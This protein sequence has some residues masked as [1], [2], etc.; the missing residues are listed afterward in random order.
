MNATPAAAKTARAAMAEA[1]EFL[2]ELVARLGEEGILESNPEIA[3]MADE[4]AT[5]IHALRNARR[6]L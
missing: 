3:A 6:G 5:H 1:A 4:A 2:A